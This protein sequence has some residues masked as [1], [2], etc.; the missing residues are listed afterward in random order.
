[1]M[2]YIKKPMGFYLIGIFL[3][4][5]IFILEVSGFSLLLPGTF[6]DNVWMGQAQKYAQMIPYR[7]PIGCAFVILGWV[8]AL[9]VVGWF[10][11]LKW[12][13][14]LALVIFVVNGIGDAVGLLNGDLKGGLL[15]VS[16][17]G[18]LIFY[19]ARPGVRELF[20]RDAKT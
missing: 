11:C 18:A 15:G 9:A 2:T 7:Y 16:I 20:K 14:W 6:L 4:L 10:R 12:G 13:W 3:A 17:A 8:F 5:S 19:L 1:M